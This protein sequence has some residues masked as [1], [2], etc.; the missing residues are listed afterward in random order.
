[1]TSHIHGFL[2]SKV[3]HLDGAAPVQFYGTK[4]EA[5]AGARRRNQTN[6]DANW[7]IQEF[8][9]GKAKGHPEEMEPA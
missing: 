2:L 5:R 1:M 9:N 4:R 6:P 3:R 7:R 8:R